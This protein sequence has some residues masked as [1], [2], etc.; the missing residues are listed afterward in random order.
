MTYRLKM[1]GRGERREGRSILIVFYHHSQWA[2]RLIISVKKK[3]REVGL[4]HFTLAVQ[5]DNSENMSNQ[6]FKRHIWNLG[7][8]VCGM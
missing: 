7:K 3:N 8:K 6:Q 4:G 1:S 5:K 2:L